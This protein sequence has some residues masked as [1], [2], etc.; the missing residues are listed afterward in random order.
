MAWSMQQK[1]KNQ[2][3]SDGRGF[4]N[5]EKQ[6]AVS[7]LLADIQRHTTN[8]C[9]PFWVPLHKVG[10]QLLLLL[11][12]HVVSSLCTICDIRLQACIYTSA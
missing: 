11:L 9:D 10:S 12:V 4:F 5:L 2:P 8:I 3:Q 1:Q 7:L 6:I